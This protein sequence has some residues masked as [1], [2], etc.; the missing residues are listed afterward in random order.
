MPDA[1]TREKIIEYYLA[2]NK[3]SNISPAFKI[4][5]TQATRNFNIKK[6]EN[7]INNT[8]LSLLLKNPVDKPFWHTYTFNA[9]DPSGWWSDYQGGFNKLV[10]TL[11]ISTS[12]TFFP[13]G[14]IAY[15]NPSNEEKH[16]YWSYANNSYSFNERIRELLGNNIH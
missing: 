4:E 2:K 7:M 15:S 11:Q 10:R 1:Q 9:I 8:M 6:I 13:F 16:L 5:L 3:I 12:L 14:L